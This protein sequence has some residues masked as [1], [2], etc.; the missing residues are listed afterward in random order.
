MPPWC[1]NYWW[2]RPIDKRRLLAYNTWIDIDEVSY[3]RVYVALLDAEESGEQIGVIAIL[4]ENID[5]D[6]QTLK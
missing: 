4:K 2:Y 3:S 6:I 5:K 1:E